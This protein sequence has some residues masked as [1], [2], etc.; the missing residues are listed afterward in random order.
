MKKDESEILTSIPGVGK[1]ISQNLFDIGIRKVSDLKGQDP[2]KLGCTVLPNPG[3]G[4][5][6]LNISSLKEDLISIKVLNM[7]GGI[8]YPVTEIPVKGKLQYL[9]DLTGQ[10]DGIYFLNIKGKESTLTKKI[11]IS[12]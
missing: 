12:K 6:R 1:S 4:N 9:L 3:N 11:I 8:V 5:F 10:P 2:E 7:I